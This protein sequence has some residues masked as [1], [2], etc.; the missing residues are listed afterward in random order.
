MLY[1]LE[2]IAKLLYEENKGNLRNH[3]IVFPSRRGGLYF[4]KYLSAQIEKPVWAPVIMTI[5][6]FFAKFSPLQ[7]AE[8]EILLFEL[9]K[10]Y[11]ELNKSAESFDEFY[12]WG[13]MLISDFDDVDKYMADAP[14]LFRNI[15]D[16][17]NID[18]QFGD[19]DPEQAQII[20]RFWKNF[21]PDKPSREKTD[22]KLL[23]A[24]LNDLYSGFRKS[25]RSA[26]LG[27]EGMI[28]REVAEKFLDGDKPEVKW[29]Q[30]HFI[31]FNALNK[32]ER[33]LMLQLQKDSLAKFYWDYDN[34][35]IKGGK[36][37]S[38]GFFLT[39]NLRNF[40]NDMPADWNYDTLLSS[41]KR[42]I[43]RSVIETTSDIAQVK[44]VSYLID[45]LPG[46]SP[47]NAHHTA[48]I[49][50]NEDL[51]VPLMTSLPQ[52][53]GDINIT[54][55]FPLKM[56][57]VYSLVKNLLDFQRSLISE[58]GTVFADYRVV[59]EIL[60]HQFI[61]N[62]L[63]DDDKKIIGEIVSKNLARVPY[64]LLCRTG[65]LKTIFRRAADPA[66]LSDHIRDILSIV[67]ATYVKDDGSEKDPGMQRSLRNEFI[68][69]ILLSVN[70][71]D[72]ITRS[73][74]VSL[75]TETYI[76][77]LD[78]ILR[79]QSV[80]FSGEPL[81]GI[82][83][84][85]ILETRALDFKNIIILSVN[86]GILPAVSAVSSFIPFSIRE[87][88]ELP[89]VNHQESI[90]AYH[91]YRLLHRAEN[92]TFVYNSNSDGLNTGEMS[93][94]LIQMK[95][96]HILNPDI[97]TPGFDIRTPVSINPEIR[98]TNELINRLFSLYLD[99][100]SKNI[101]SPT[102]INTW[103]NCRMKFYY[104]YVSRLKEPEVIAP[105]IEHA[106]F[107]QI[108]HRVMKNIY[109]NYKGKEISVSFVDSLIKSESYLHSAVDLA[110]NENYSCDMMRPKSGN[111][112]II[113]D[114]LYIYLQRI[115]VADKGMAP[116]TIIDLEKPLH[117]DLS[118]ELN[119]ENKRIRTGGNIDRVDR[120]S[121]KTRVVDYKTG[122]VGRKISSISDLF[123]DDRDKESDGW[124]QTLLYCEAYLS[125]NPGVIVRP[126][127]YKVKEYYREKSSD[128]L[129]IKNEKDSEIS[130]EDYQNVRTS[131]LEGVKALAATIFSPEE[132]F[133]MTTKISKCEYC[134][135]K[136]LCQR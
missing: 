99:K 6:E 101:L 52:N 86:E 111:D 74:E 21:E 118:F 44:L 18:I 70:Q 59:F 120:I 55:G 2:R 133:R 103:L 11:R 84:M 78:I 45:R 128:T 41:G 127:I 61:E 13:A 121:G 91:F 51:L 34:S 135:Y 126:S 56:T 73:P 63:N 112:L 134:P 90:Y 106:V 97:Q 47:E 50:A 104:R 89:S 124:L 130:I 48:V 17:K 108:L 80:P 129:I 125:E 77:I 15:K 28:A 20:K 115:L 60:K 46:I 82:Q 5:N 29:N 68:Y 4:L 67:S 122:E 24:I 39:N 114:I 72:T 100:E 8:N 85:G 96:E 71:L 57:A 88:F 131:F 113:K 83:I 94:F 69:R 49:L 53:K 26:N 38:A 136:T 110:V 123:V 92:V 43:S 109:E 64:D 66:Q 7:V 25:L 40:S 79:N 98:R 3:C 93:R 132:P 37:N 76:R 10:V 35:Y 65:N 32:C 87:A 19:I 107:G 16:F 33:T 42:D 105:E 102:A 23:W 31:G 75:K 54:M 36:L 116:F 62:F 12:F 27:Y 9:Y 14:V 117:F 58:N 22:F 30:V 119:G 1:F 95:Y 81:S